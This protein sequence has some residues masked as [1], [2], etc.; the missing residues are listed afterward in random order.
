ML[1]LGVKAN[2]YL[3]VVL[4]HDP[5]DVINVKSKLRDV[6]E[7]LGKFRWRAPMTPLVQHN[8]AGRT[9]TECLLVG[10]GPE[11]KELDG[12]DWDCVTRVLAFP[13]PGLLHHTQL[14]V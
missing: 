3:L 4:G 14:M 10:V 7:T 2:D 1:R 6:S 12:E 13:E 9:D 5:C 11:A 8:G